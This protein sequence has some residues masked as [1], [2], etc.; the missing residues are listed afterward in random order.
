[1]G[2]KKGKATHVAPLRPPTLAAFQ[3]WGDSEGAGRV[4]LS[5]S[6]NI[7]LFIETVKNEGEDVVDLRELPCL[8]SPEHNDT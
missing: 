5:P 7:L 2:R 4:R 8:F 6:A 1:M 3:P